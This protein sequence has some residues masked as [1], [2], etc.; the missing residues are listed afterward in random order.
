MSTGTGGQKVGLGARIAE[1][2]RAQ[3][4]KHAKI[5]VAS[6][7]GVSEQMAKRW[8]RGIAPAVWHLEE[9]SARWGRKFV[10]HAFQDAIHA[11]EAVWLKR[12]RRALEAQLKRQSDALD[13]EMAAGP[14]GVGSVGRAMA[15]AGRATVRGLIGRVRIKGRAA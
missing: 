14:R 3:Y 5:A 11:A 2:L 4:P 13:T 10:T 8:L 9:M 1:W 7:F 12:R 15:R 6:E